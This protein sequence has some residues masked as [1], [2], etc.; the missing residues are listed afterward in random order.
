MNK[1]FKISVITPVYNAED[2]LEQTLECIA[3]QTIGFADNVQS[4]LVNDG[5]TDSSGDICRA[6]A[7]KYPEIVVYIVK[8]N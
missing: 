6:F 5:S 2:F 1:D 7:E 3:G 8:E 4:I